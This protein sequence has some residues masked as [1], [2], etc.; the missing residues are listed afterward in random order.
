V[1][2]LLRGEVLR[3]NVDDLMAEEEA[4]NLLLRGWGGA[5][6]ISYCYNLSKTNIGAM[7]LDYNGTPKTGIETSDP[8]GRMVKVT[9]KCIQPNWS[10]SRQNYPLAT[11]YIRRAEGTQITWSDDPTRDVKS[12]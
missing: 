12:N 5:V 2:L 7:S 4:E 11:I 10:P 3:V 8:P 9:E 6:D 1:A